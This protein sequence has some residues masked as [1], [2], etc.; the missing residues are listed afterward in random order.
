MKLALPILL[1]VALGLS[2]A[3]GE[4]DFL[5]DAARSDAIMK[6]VGSQLDSLAR[7]MEI[8]NV[9][10][11][12]D[13][14][15]NRQVS[16][17]LAATRNTDMKSVL[18][19][20]ELS[21]LQATN[22]NTHLKSA[23]A[24]H[25]RIA[26]SLL[27]MGN[28]LGTGKGTDLL[29]RDKLMALKKEVEA[30]AAETDAGK[31][32]TEDQQRRADDMAREVRNTEKAVNNAE[33]AKAMEAAAGKLE[34]GKPEAAAEEINKA[35]ASLD[36]ESNARENESAAAEAK[37]NA[38]EKAAA[39]L[40]ALAKQAQTLADN[41]TTP[42]AGDMALDMMMKAEEVAK[43]GRWVTVYYGWR[44]N[45]RDEG[46]NHLIELAIAGAARA[47]VTHNVRDVRGGELRWSD[48]LVVT[49]SQCLEQMR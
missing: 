37:K 40:N 43:Q 17:Q 16:A 45:L 30:L 8:S 7:E 4:D 28:R 11:P 31:A 6:D 20:L 42:K 35:L 33:A 14:T 1:M 13:I 44:P 27:E 26:R 25:R 29:S 15:S 18:R 2:P 41:P 3:F 39:Q 19:S 9:F 23:E 46:D 48:L 24:G 12:S 22:L 34:T 10:A 21:Q 32:L 36:K 38:L 5:R 47:I 49:P